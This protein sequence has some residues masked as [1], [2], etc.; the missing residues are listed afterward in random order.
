VISRVIHLVTDLVLSP[1]EVG[2]VLKI[3]LG[4]IICGH[5]R[6]KV[7]TCLG[8]NHKLVSDASFLGPLAYELFRGSVL[9]DIGGC[10]L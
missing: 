4:H 6:R 7:W 1:L 9:T 8:R 10:Q 5:V 2:R 3:K